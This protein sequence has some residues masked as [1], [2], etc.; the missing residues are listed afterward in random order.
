[1]RKVRELCDSKLSDNIDNIDNMVVDWV[2]GTPILEVI[3]VTLIYSNQWRP[4][5]HDI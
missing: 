3:F 1:M 2:H 5:I 4:G